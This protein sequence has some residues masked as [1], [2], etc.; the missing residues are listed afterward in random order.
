MKVKNN[1]E[2]YDTF[3]KNVEELLINSIC[4]DLME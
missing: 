3:R 1:A 2:F 4:R